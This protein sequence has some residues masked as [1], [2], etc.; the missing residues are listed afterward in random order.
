LHRVI[1]NQHAPDDVFGDLEHG[2]EIVMQ[3]VLKDGYNVDADVG[4]TQ[5]D[6]RPLRNLLPTCKT[7]VRSTSWRHVFETFLTVGDILIT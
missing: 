7:S 5:R 1:H 3:R 4:E 6:N 2:H